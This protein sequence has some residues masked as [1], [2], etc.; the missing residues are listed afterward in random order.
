MCWGPAATAQPLPPQCP[1]CARPE[2]KHLEPISS[3]R[4]KKKKRKS[5]AFRAALVN[6]HSGWAVFFSPGRRKGLHAGWSGD[7]WH[8]MK[9]RGL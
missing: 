7:V 1:S 2:Q 6:N 5:K 3:P 9:H 4:K 8:E